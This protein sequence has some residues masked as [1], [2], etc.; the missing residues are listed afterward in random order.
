MRVSKEI[1]GQQRS[2]ASNHA[3]NNKRAILAEEIQHYV[4]ACIITL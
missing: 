2:F 1:M 4:C 3:L